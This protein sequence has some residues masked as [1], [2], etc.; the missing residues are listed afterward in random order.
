MEIRVC[1]ESAWPLLPS[2]S[3]KVRLYLSED[4]RTHV[5]HALGCEALLCL[6]L[7]MKTCVSL[8]LLSHQDQHWLWD[9]RAVNL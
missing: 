1:S 2:G 9:N 6:S 5:A 7:S 3:P 4:P 8:P